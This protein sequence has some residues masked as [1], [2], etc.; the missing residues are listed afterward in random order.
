MASRTR[1]NPDDR[2]AQLI[3]TAAGAFAAQPYDD[4]RMDE[5]AERAEVSRGLLYRYF[6]TKRDL[7]AAVYRH[8]ARDLLDRTRFDAERDLLEQIVAGLEVHFD[9]FEENRNTFLGANRVL[10]GD[11]LIQ[12]TIDKGLAGLRDE[13]IKVAGLSG[14]SRD[15]AAAAV[16][17]WLTF[18]R[19]LCVEWQATGE[20]TRDELR[21]MCLGALTGALGTSIPALT[22]TR[23]VDA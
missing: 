6:P 19:T 1:L 18:V 8:A 22:Q 12:T 3:R 7:F 9:F 10:A 5:I 14:R 16:L 4:V 2:R 11:P 17:A 15:L 21:T 20:F 13:V 23:D